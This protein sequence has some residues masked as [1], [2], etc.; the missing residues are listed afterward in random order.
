MSTPRRYAVTGTVTVAGTAKT[1]I[2][3][4]AT[5]A[6]RPAIFD[7][8]VG[9]T[10]TPADNVCTWSVKRFTASGTRTGVTP[11]LLDSG[12][13]A[14]TALSGQTHT[15]EPTYTASTVLWEA[16][17]NQRATYRWVAAPGAELV[18]PATASNGI[19][20]YTLSTAY[21]STAEASVMF[22]E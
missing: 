6:I 12:D 9:T 4:V 20:I 8:T 5:A 15:V 14:A 21:A 1:A 17:I 13:P 19:G 7:F 18:M 11:S 10:G 16:G 2:D 22:N 3:V